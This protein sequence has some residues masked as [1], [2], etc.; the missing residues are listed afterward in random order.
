MIPIGQIIEFRGP[1]SFTEDIKLLTEV[2]KTGWVI[3]NTASNH[4]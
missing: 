3:L 2:D 4:T 1:Q